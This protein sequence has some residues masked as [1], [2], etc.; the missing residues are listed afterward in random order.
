MDMVVRN[1][2]E[3]STLC[4][5]CSVVVDRTVAEPEDK[6]RGYAITVNDLGHVSNGYEFAFKSLQRDK[7][8][9]RPL[10]MADG[11]GF[12][13]QVRTQKEGRK[14]WQ[15]KRD[16]WETEHRRHLLD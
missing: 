15:P 4:E 9:S 3:H 5:H 6:A 14:Q 12:G 13:Q 8:M 1:E 10:K 7:T 11:N 2:T 16:G